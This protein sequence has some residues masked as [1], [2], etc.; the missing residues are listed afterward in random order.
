MN[1]TSHECINGKKPFDAKKNDIW[2]NGVCLFM[3][4]IGGN[5]PS[6]DLVMNGKLLKSIKSWNRL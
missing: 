6:Y 5:I 3:M 1:Y 2:S 4:I